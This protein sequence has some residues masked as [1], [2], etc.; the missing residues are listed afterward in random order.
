MHP[1]GDR[2]GRDAQKGARF[3]VRQAIPGQQAKELL[4]TRWQSRK[5]VEDRRSSRR[6]VRDRRRLFPQSKVESEPPL[7]T[8]ALVGDQA[9]RDAKQPGQHSSI[10]DGMQ[11]APGD[12]KRLR[13]DILRILEGI[14]PPQDI[15]HDTA[16]MLV[17]HRLEAPELG[18]GRIHA[19]VTDRGSLRFLARCPVATIGARHA[20][21]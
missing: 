1:D 5:S 21:P 18:A 6:G 4:V 11:P 14:D 7:V 16:M 13:D 3:C 10:R 2:V 17:E 12:A 9:A 19:S 8:P 20:S 15:G